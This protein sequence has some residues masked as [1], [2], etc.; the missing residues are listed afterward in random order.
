MRLR[1]VPAA[2]RFFW[3]QQVFLTLIKDDRYIDDRCILA[4]PLDWPSQRVST[5]LASLQVKDINCS[6]HNI[7]CSPRCLVW[8][9]RL[10]V[11]MFFTLVIWSIPPRVGGRIHASWRNRVVVGSSALFCL[12]SIQNWT[13]TTAALPTVSFRSTA[14]SSFAFGSLTWPLWHPAAAVVARRQSRRVWNER[15]RWPRRTWDN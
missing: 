13:S 9:I 4:T 5:H 12:Q 15:W 2:S 1:T 6:P 8:R 11:A 7:N 10:R 14:Q 3:H